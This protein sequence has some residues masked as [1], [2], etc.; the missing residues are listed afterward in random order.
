MVQYKGVGGTSLSDSSHREHPQVAIVI[1]TRNRSEDLRRALS[2]CVSQD[3]PELEIR[4]YDDCSNDGTAEMVMR[5][6]SSVKLSSATRRVGRLHLR[7]VAFL[8]TQAEYII[9]MDDDAWFTDVATVTELMRHVVREPRTAV[10]AIPF[11]EERP[12][13]RETTSCYAPLG[14]ELKSYV[15]AAYLCRVSALRAVGGYH[16]FLI[17]QW[18]ERDLCV[19]LRSAGWTIRMASTAPMVHAVS[20]Y[21]ERSEMQRYGVRNQVLHDFFYAPW[22]IV[23][24]VAARHIY[25]LLTYR[26]STRCTA[27]T[28][29]YTIEGIRDC[30]TYREYRSPLTPAA[31]L[32]HVALPNHGPR[33]V[34]ATELPPPCS[35]HD[36]SLIGI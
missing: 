14:S 30:W 8:E 3:Y 9:G 15:A 31:Y 18:E 11:L 12:A 27:K 2:S 19:R 25:R 16:E 34:S 24:I 33:Y 13:D 35:V 36:L 17:Y 20:R 10:F 23:P 5:E 6:F 1:T 22:F 26:L 32:A 21:R 4:V 7:N 29:L 28:L